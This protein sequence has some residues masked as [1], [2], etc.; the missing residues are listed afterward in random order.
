M[1]NCGNFAPQ[2]GIANKKRD[3]RYFTLIVS[4]CK[5]N[6]HNC[7][8]LIVTWLDFSPNTCYTIPMCQGW[9]KFPIGGDVNILYSTSP[10]AKAESVWLRYRR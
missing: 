9:V 5:A 7:S 2:N 6:F 1:N 8:L 10:R 4:I 3:L